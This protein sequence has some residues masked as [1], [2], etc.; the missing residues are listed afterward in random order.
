MSWLNA[1]GLYI[2]FGQEEAVAGKGG[3]FATPDGGNVHVI[4]FDLNLASLPSAAA[5][6]S[7]NIRVPS[8]FYVKEVELFVKTAAASSG[9]GTLN[10]G[11]IRSDRA[12]EEDYD[13]LAAAVAVTA[14]DAVGDVVSLIQGG[15]GHGALVGTQLAATAKNGYFTAHYGTAVFQSGVVQVRV[16]L[17][18]A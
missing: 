17:V 3:Q 2:K 11:I 14:V 15:T 5:I 16:H 9:G 1:D 18:R 6:V 13:G 4:E 7:D 8:G 10:V 12:T